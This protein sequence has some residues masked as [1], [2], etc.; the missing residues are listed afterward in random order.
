MRISK[1]MQTQQ[2]KHFKPVVVSIIQTY[3]P[4]PPRQ[5]LDELLTKKLTRKRGLPNYR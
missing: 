3:R 1:I 2:F 5:S 4:W